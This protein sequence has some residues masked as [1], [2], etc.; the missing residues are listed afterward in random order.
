MM[1]FCYTVVPL[2]LNVTLSW[3]IKQLA[4]WN[5]MV[6]MVATFFIGVIAFLLPPVPGMTVYIFGGLIVS[7]T[8]PAGFFWGAI[9]NIFLCWF[10]KLAACAV[11]QKCIG[12]VLGQSIWVRQTVGVHKVAIRCIEA[13][14]RKPGWTMGKVA[15]LCGGPDWPVS[16][17][18]G[19]L[20]LSLIQCEIGTIPIIFF[21][22]PCDRIFLPEEG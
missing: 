5:F 3:I 10:L 2:L 15:I 7:D 18:A 19:V 11:Q 9:I 16:V 17:L 6:I 8:C 4:S 13:E 22:G 20:G 1:Y 12:G 21:V 14:M